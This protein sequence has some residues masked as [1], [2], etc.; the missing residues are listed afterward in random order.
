MT[1]E[2][3]L[4]TLLAS[5]SATARDERYVYVTVS[6]EDAET[7]GAA[8]SIVEDE[9]TTLVIP[10]AEADAL[11]LGY[12]YVAGWITLEVYSALSAVGLT[13]VVSSALA[14]AGISCNILAGFHHDHLLVPEDRLDAALEVLAG[15][16][17]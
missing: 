15:L 8:A 5:L 2:G 10:Q 3:D 14:E 9:G 7:I 4:A 13:A 16:S 17:G 1:A 6:H 12:D 11:G